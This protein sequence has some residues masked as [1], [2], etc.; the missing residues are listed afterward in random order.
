MP[1]LKERLEAERHEAIAAEHGHLEDVWAGRLG[2]I[3]RHQGR[4]E[5][6]SSCE[7][8]NA[9]NNTVKNE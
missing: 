5:L 9:P 3:S 4:L 2:P 7:T 8:R 6:C 1:T